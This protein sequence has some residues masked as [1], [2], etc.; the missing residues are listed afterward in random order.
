MI[1]VTET[2]SEGSVG[3]YDFERNTT[4]DDSYLSVYDNKNNEIVFT[5]YNMNDGTIRFMRESYIGD[6]VGFKTGDGSQI[7]GTLEA[8]LPRT[9]NGKDSVSPKV[10]V[11]GVVY[12]T[13]GKYR[14]DPNAIRNSTGIDIENGKL[15]VWY[16]E[17]EIG[18]ILE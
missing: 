18:G 12:S 2:F 7:I 6:S 16:I 10:I 15:T 14:N 13:T 8:I 3:W 4:F 11:D 9:E 17:D 1:G 5:G